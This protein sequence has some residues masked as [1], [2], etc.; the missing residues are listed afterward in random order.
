MDQNRGDGAVHAPGETA[1]HPTAADLLAN[2]FDLCVAE[3]SHRPVAGAAA[4]VAHEVGEELPAVG[5]VHHLRMEHEAV[6]LRLFIRGDRERRTFRTSDDLKAR[7]ERLDAVA[8]THP[9]LVLLTNL[10]QT[11]EQSRRRH[12]VDERAAEFLLVRRNDLAAELLVKRLL[13]VADAEKRKAA[14][15]HR[16]WS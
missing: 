8:V 10:P 5:R 15:K 7:R 2:L 14:V 6:A 9:H 1:D 12:D 13:A 16:L 11:V 4:D 3:A